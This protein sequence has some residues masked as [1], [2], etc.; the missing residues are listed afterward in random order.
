MTSWSDADGREIN[1]RGG[2]SLPPIHVMSELYLYLN[3]Y[4]VAGRLSATCMTLQDYSSVLCRLGHMVGTWRRATREGTARISQTRT[5][6]HGPMQR[7]HSVS[8]SSCG[9]RSGWTKTA[10]FE[11]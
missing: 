7:R 2:L 1:K 3:L 4:L 5:R 10:S 9:M 11:V 6:L 8:Q